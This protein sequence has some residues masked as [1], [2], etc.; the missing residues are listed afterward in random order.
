MGGAGA[1]AFGFL[2]A[3]LMFASPLACL[4][5]ALITWILV[6]PNWTLAAFVLFVASC[7]LHLIMWNVEPEAVMGKIAFSGSFALSVGALLMIPAALAFRIGA[8]IFAVSRAK[9]QRHS[10]PETGE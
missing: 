5:A 7:C 1:G 9:Q 6:L 4:I 3:A 8:L 10:H 2:F